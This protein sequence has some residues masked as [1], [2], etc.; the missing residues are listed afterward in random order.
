MPELLESILVI[1]NPNNFAKI[2][3]KEIQKA[4]I[5]LGRMTESPSHGDN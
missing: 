5:V 4:K 3:I 1:E 2:T